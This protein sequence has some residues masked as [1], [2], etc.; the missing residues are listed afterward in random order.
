MAEIVEWTFEGDSETETD[1]QS[2]TFL[3]LVRLFLMNGDREYGATE[4][5]TVI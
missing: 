5:V 2:F 3:L 1:Y 4:T